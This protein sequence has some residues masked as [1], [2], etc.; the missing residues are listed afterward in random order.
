MRQAGL[1]PGVGEDGLDR[2]GEA[3]QAV[4]AADQ[5]VGDAALLELGENLQPELRA[6]GALKPRLAMTARSDRR[7]ESQLD[8]RYGCEP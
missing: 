8:G 7:G 6:F 2:L 3:G 1:R 4:D 5:H